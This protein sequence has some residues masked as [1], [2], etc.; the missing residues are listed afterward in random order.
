VNALPELRTAPVKS[1]GYYTN[2]VWSGLVW[3][4]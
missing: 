2:L 4:D 1:G 3:I